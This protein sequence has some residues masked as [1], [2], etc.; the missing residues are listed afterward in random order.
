M[1]EGP[2]LWFVNRGTG[3]VLLIL[4]TLST[5]LGVVATRVRGGRMPQFAYQHLHR[6]LGLVSVGLLAAHATSAVVD[7]FVD[8]RWWQAFVPW[9]GS[10]KPIWLGLGA[11]ALDLIVL[12][13]L[14]SLLRR[15]L[16]HLGWRVVHVLAYAAWA[17]AVVHGLGIGTDAQAPWSVWLT[18]G[19]VVAVAL[20]AL[21]RLLGLVRERWRPAV[22]R[23]GARANV[24]GHPR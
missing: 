6:N 11:L 3:V 19:C 9:G 13:T 20:A 14:T 15:R 5:V 12:V 18:L 16:P 22:S 10:Y 2:L 4:L 17:V 7:T 23:P 1:M 8:I 21:A 24:W